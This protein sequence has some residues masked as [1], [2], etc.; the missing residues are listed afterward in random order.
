[1]RKTN[2]KSICTLLRITTAIL[3]IFGSLLC[4]GSIGSLELGE[5]SF[6]QFYLKELLAFS[7]VGLA[8]V[9]YVARRVIHYSYLRRRHANYI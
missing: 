9:S 1:M 3:S 4:F 6:T 8:Y 2:I 5:I 7:L